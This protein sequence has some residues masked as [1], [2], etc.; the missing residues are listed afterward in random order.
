VSDGSDG[1]SIFTLAPRVKNFRLTPHVCDLNLLSSFRLA[2]S[3]ST[4]I[5]LSHQLL[6]VVASSVPRCLDATG[7][8]PQHSH[9]L[10]WYHDA[11]SLP[12]AALPAASPCPAAWLLPVVA[13][14]A[15][16]THAPPPLR[17][18]YPSRLPTALEEQ[19]CSSTCTSTTL[20]S[21]RCMARRR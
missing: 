7:G 18:R 17:H 13:L 11:S 8:R 6:H 15:A 4:R 10:P 20:A 14:A 9:L 21:L 16:S 12:A 1:T 5:A 19:R 2:A 3:F